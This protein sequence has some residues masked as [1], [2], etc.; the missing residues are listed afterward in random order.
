MASF[1]FFV[2]SNLFIASCAVLMV[3][4]SYQLLLHAD[5]DPYLLAFVFFSTI[6]SYSFHWYL[7]SDSA[8]GSSRS[9][10][11]Q[12]NHYI[13]VIFFIIGLIGS[14]IFFFTLSRH[15]FWL[16]LSAVPTFLYTAPKIPNKYF[17][18]LRKIA[19]GKTIFLSMVWM[20][21][22][23]ILP[24]VINDTVWRADTIL[25]VASRFF[26][27]YAICILFDRRDREED[28]AKGIRSLITFL[29]EGGIK[30]LFI[31]SLLIFGISTFG[32]GFYQYSA[33][34]VFLLLIP[35]II[36]SFLYN[37]AWKKSSDILYYFTLDGLM[38]LSSVLT[39]LTW[40]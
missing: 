27:I 19:L 33:I 30:T 18:A 39:L 21:V 10:W 26:L 8:P 29:N 9:L 7:S 15:W 11:Q 23:T 32:L 35:G 14:A 16:L 38:A 13:H 24:V 17:R 5:P 28:K 12:Q 3:S 25:F 22:T 31:L 20:Y 40:I 6:C 4:Q 1:K 34:T 36:T 37:Y 2:Y